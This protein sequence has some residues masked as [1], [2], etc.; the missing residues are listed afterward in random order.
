LGLLKAQM[1]KNAVIV[2][3]GAKGGF[4]LKQQDGAGSPAREQV[5]L[6]YRTFVQGLLDLSDNLRDA[7]IVRPPDTVRY[8]DDDPY[9]VVAADKGTATFS[10]IAN[11]LSADNDFWLGD[12]FASGGSAGYDHKKIGITAKGAWESVSRHF[13]ELGTDIK[14]QPFSVVG[15][16]DM[17][18]DVFGNGML[19]SRQIKL[20]A[21]FN[22]RHIFID[23]APDPERSYNERERLFNTER[24]QWSD[25]DRSVLSKGGGVYERSAKRIPLSPEARQ[26]LGTSAASMAPNEVIQAILRA[27]VDLLWNG[28]IGTFVKASHESHT[29]ANDHSNDAN[30]IDA[31]ELRCRVVGEGGN[32]GF[33]QQARIEFAV[34]GGLIN[35]D[36]IDN[37]GGVDCSDR[38]VNIKILL[39]LA[40]SAQQLDLTTRN[41]LLAEMTDD[42]A[43]LVLRDNYLQTRAISYAVA[44]PKKKVGAYSRML[45]YLERYSGLDRSLEGLPN[46]EDL[47][48]RL[49]AGTG[50]T[51]PELAVIESYT[52]LGLYDQLLSSDLVDDEDCSHMLSSYFPQVLYERYSDYIAQHPLRRE[53]IATLLAN[54]IAHSVDF[55]FARRVGEQS[56]RSVPEMARAFIAAGVIFN[57]DDL[58]GRV[59]SLDNKVTA[60]LQTQLMWEIGRL[61]ERASFWLLRNRPQPLAIDETIRFFA[62]QTK[63]LEYRLDQLVSSDERRY[64][65]TRSRELRKSG[66]P[67]DSAAKFAHLDAMFS[68]LDIVE[69]C[70][71]LE[72]DLEF[73]AR[74]YFE[75]GRRFQ[76]SWLREQIAVLPAE[77]HLQGIAKSNLYTDLYRSQ[78]L[79]AAAAL[80]NNNLRTPKGRIERWLKAEAD[81]FAHTEQLLKEARSGE[82]RDLAM[83]FVIVRDIEQLAADH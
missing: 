77:H 20:I 76:M 81:R 64:Q 42:V 15:I 48:D 52:K 10:D 31:S 72:H 29:D 26:A 54:R 2:P 53:I 23:P 17:A 82:L 74:V 30:R 1:V 37:S 57:F 80:T 73:T 27:P 69:V 24:S 34:R 43:R 70:S 35:T 28:G 58:Q 13:S 21:A 8:D 39:R 25:F 79:L 67:E 50:L 68:A 55:N 46:D 4:V 36:F 45:R 44:Q 16:G 14:V 38:E 47:A 33:T 71:K 5:V 63:T 49:R 65:R 18:G 41:N 11:S 61:I 51:R 75:V 32:L 7:Q 22:H 12:A 56:G 66:V 40:Q 83:L 59:E 9:L 78:R 3:V 19:L 62:E 60:D 6:A